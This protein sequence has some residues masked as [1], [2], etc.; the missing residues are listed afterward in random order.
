MREALANLDVR[1]ARRVWAV[2]APHLPQPKSDAEVLATLHLARTQSESMS[3]RQRGYSHRW[4]QDRGLPSGLPDELKPRAER[5]YP[6][7]AR[8]VGI[9]V[10]FKNEALRPLGEAVRRSMENVVKDM[11]ANGDTDPALI[12]RRM[13]EAKNLEI[14]RMVG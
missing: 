7:V 10:N 6:R 12:K 3:L 13:L 1:L 11:Y 2:I 14:K 5:M 9:S 4:L 8:A